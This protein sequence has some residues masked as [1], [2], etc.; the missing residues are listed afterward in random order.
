MNSAC[1]SSVAAKA[2]VSG[3][4]FACAWRVSLAKKDRDNPAAGWSESYDSAAGALQAA[5]SDYVWRGGLA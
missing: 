3:A 2:L 1:G 5:P 4:S